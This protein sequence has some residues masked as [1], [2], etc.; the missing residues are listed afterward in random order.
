MRLTWY[1]CCSVYSFYVIF[2][3]L[4]F[5]IISVLSGFFYRLMSFIFPLVSSD[6]WTEYN[7]YLHWEKWTAF[8]SMAP[9][10][11]PAY[12]VPLVAHSAVF[13]ELF[14]YTYWLVIGLCFRSFLIFTD[15]VVYFN[16]THNLYR[17]L[18]IVSLSHFI[19]QILL[20][21]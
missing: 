19:L 18:C 2:Y 20:L 12:G 15:I 4:P 5:T 8:P 3:E 10:F 14:Y 21:I 16:W 13:C 11:I 1:S 7:L 17:F 6:S 9:S